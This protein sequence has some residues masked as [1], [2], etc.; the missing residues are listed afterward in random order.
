ML[1]GLIHLRLAR[2][3]LL[4]VAH[5]EHRAHTMADAKVGAGSLSWVNVAVQ[6]DPVH[7]VVEA[8][9]IVALSFESLFL[10]VH[11]TL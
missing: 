3:L 2:H 4:V 5:V 10:D 11:E 1:E 8:L 9:D 6:A 7:S